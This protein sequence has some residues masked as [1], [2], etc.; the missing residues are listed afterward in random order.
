MSILK[1]EH[2]ERIAKY[3]HAQSLLRSKLLNFNTM[4]MIVMIVGFGCGIDQIIHLE[5]QLI[6]RIDFALMYQMGKTTPKPRPL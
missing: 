4:L 6:V 1:Y 3:R 2:R 5:Q